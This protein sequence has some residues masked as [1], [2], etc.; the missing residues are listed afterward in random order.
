MYIHFLVPSCISLA[1]NAVAKR[2]EFKIFS[3]DQ[4]SIPSSFN[5]HISCRLLHF[6]HLV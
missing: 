3:L 4:F 5:S 6:D 2:P 1:A